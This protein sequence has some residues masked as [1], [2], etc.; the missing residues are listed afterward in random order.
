MSISD[1]LHSLFMAIALAIAAYSIAF[2]YS[3]ALTLV[4]SSAIVFVLV[5]YSLTTPIAIK[6]LARVEKANEKASS[7][8]GEIFSSIRT[9]FSLGAEPALTKKYV[10]C[11]DE[12]KRHGLAGSLT[13]GIQLS[14]VFFAMYSSFAL[15]FWFG[16]KLFREGHITDIST[17]IM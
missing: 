12:S 17:V 3:W 16:L 10:S 11:V 1:K 8:A 14:P 6:S 2:R 15:A 7:I 9:V 13:W 4:T 5:V